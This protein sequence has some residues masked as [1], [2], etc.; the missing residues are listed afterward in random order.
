[1][2]KILAHSEKNLS[3]CTSEAEDYLN[4]LPLFCDGVSGGFCNHPEHEQ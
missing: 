2:H 3:E 1:M 4:D